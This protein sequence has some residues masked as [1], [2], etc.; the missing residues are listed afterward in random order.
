M[1]EKY[2]AEGLLIIEPREVIINEL[3]VAQGSS[4]DLNRHFTEARVLQSRSLVDRLV[5]DLGLATHPALVGVAETEGNGRQNPGPISAFIQTVKQTLGPV[6]ELLQTWKRAVSTLLMG[7]KDEAEISPPGDPNAE[8]TTAILKDLTITAT[9]KSSA[10]EVAFSSEDPELSAAIVNRLMALYLADQVRSRS[11]ATAQV[12]QVL[13]ARMGSLRQEVEDADKRV[14]EYRLAHGLIETGSGEMNVLRLVELQRQ[15]IDASALEKTLQ[16]RVASATQTGSADSSAEVLASALI[17]RLR[18]Q[19]ATVSSRLSRLSRDLG[20]RHPEA[21]ALQEELSNLRSQITAETRKV[22][23]SLQSEYAVA[24]QRVL[25]LET[26]IAEARTAAERSAKDDVILQQ[27]VREANAKRGVFEAYL[28]RVQQTA[29]SANGPSPGARIASA[30][31]VPQVGQRPSVPVMGGLAGLAGFALGGAF[32]I[33]IEV[34]RKRIFN[35]DELV[36]ATGF[37]RLGDVP[38][39]S[40]WR[41]QRLADVVVTKPFVAAGESV[42]GLWINLCASVSETKVV[43]VTS[44]LPEEGKT[45]LV[46]ALGRMAAMD[47]ARVAVVDCDFRKAGIRAFF[48][49]PPAGDHV[50]CVDELLNG[51]GEIADIRFQKDRLTGMMFLPA[52]GSLAA[53]HVALTGPRLEQLIVKLRQDFD[54]ILIDSPPVLNVADPVI[55]IRRVDVLLYVASWARTPRKMIVEAVRRLNV[56]ETTAAFSV[57]TRVK[58]SRSRGGYYTGYKH[59]RLPPALRRATG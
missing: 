36:Q 27:L 56:P 51:A 43:M 35:G 26:T 31:L 30:A 10:I 1:P 42:R 12:N 38:D 22:I 13:T 11:E 9:E 44:S 59:A 33:A 40:G 15:L 28:S 58:P 6:K 32:L 4:Q 47:G 52:A 25:K 53:P 50:T 20:P 19:E 21:Q 48:G 41:R 55:L 24:Q 18:E 2:T 34:T 29:H 37:S 39:A 54:L 3:G 14:Q 8:A 57:L 45:S 5:S 23:L 46:V 49:D 7:E 16:S 17:Q